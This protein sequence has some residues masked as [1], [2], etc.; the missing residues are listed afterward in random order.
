MNVEEYFNLIDI[1]KLKKSIASFNKLDLK[2][3]SDKDIEKAFIKIIAVNNK[4]ISPTYFLTIPEDELFC[5]VRNNYDYVD[6]YIMTKK[7]NITNLL[8]NPNPKIGR[9]NK[10]MERGLY[11]SNNLN[12]AIKECNIND[13]DVFT[14]AVFKPKNK[15]SIISTYISNKYGD[16]SEANKEKA[17]LLNK[18]I[19]DLLIETENNNSDIYRITNIIAKVLYKQFV[20]DGLLFFSSKNDKDFNLFIYNESINNLEIKYIFNCKKDN[21]IIFGQFVEVNNN[22]IVPSEIS[23]NIKNEILHKIGCEIVKK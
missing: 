16:I 23:D 13:G 21:K 20:A 12:T 18:F 22:K 11:L 15:L 5:R 4:I 17:H 8:N 10:D 2:S 14:V 7:F 6:D 3:M 19:K 9:L 1:K